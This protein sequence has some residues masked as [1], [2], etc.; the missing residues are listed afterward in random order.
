[1]ALLASLDMLLVCATPTAGL[2]TLVTRSIGAAFTVPP[3]IVAGV[4]AVGGC[5]AVATLISVAIASGLCTLSGRFRMARG[6]AMPSAAF[7][8][9][10]VAPAICG[11]A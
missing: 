6:I 1:V 8:G 2:T 5:S 7:T 3:D 4:P 9:S 11:L 10:V